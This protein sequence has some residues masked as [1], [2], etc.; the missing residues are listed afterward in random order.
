MFQPG[1]PR[2]PEVDFDQLLSGV[3]GKLGSIAGR[4]GG[5]GVGGVAILAI[6]L[7]AVL[8]LATGIYRTGPGEEAAQRR[9][10]KICGAA[11]GPCEEV[12][13]IVTQTGLHWWWP[14]PIGKKDVV[15]VTETRRM[16]LGF[17][18][19]ADQGVA[20]A[21]VPVEG[22]MISGDLNIVDVQMV[23]QYDIKDLI[24]YLFRVNDPGEDARGIAPGNP[25]GRT[26]KDAAEA[27]LRL[28]VGQRS[29]ED[30]LTE[31]RTAVE[32]DTKT[33][34]QDILDRYVAG[35]NIVSVQ[36]LRTQAPEEVFESFED[37]LRAR[38]EQETLVNEALAYENNIIPRAEGDAE[39]IKREAEAF[40]QARVSRARGESSRF[41][42]VLEQFRDHSLELRNVLQDTNNADDDGDPSTGIG[43]GDVS[44]IGG[45]DVDGD[46]DGFD[47]LASSMTLIGAGLGDGSGCLFTNAETVSDSDTA[48]TCAFS[49]SFDAQ[50]GDLVSGVPFSI[51]YLG[52][53]ILT[54]P[55][56]VGTGPF[57]M[58]LDNPVLDTDNSDRDDTHATGISATDIKVVSGP[59]GG[60]VQGIDIAVDGFDARTNVVTFRVQDGETLTAGD[61]FTVQYLNRENLKVPATSEVTQ[62]RLY[63][64]A[65]EEILPVINKVIVSPDA[66]SVIIL[67]GREGIT[68]IPVGPSQAP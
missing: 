12:A 10:G 56:L 34:L 11:L 52:N 40:A 4:L 43:L 60:K 32:S 22:L 19:G 46:G 27:A 31:Q 35:I 3:K 55:S 6:G 47:I 13:G 44:V 17:R 49:V 38:Q 54:L 50:T 59:D 28:V 20:D 2:Q 67:G 65:I 42:S 1:G 16:E 15:K 53:E 8:W 5:G 26:L 29:I 61:G 51:A 48:V 21:A 41:I 68:P 14:G 39:R 37:V 24:G 25:E 33:R 45:P 57:E 36:L 9:F 66:E 58:R 30:V 64:E 18:S 63:L 23:V 7:I 62:Q